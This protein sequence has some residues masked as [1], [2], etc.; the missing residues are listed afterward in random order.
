MDDTTIG[1]ELD[2]HDIMENARENLNSV[3]EN[4]SRVVTDE[5]FLDTYAQEYCDRLQSALIDLLNVRTK[6]H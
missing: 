3:I 4:L 2:L 1:E 5:D 6:L